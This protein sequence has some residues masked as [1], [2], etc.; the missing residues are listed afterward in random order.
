LNNQDNHNSL[1]IET[2]HH[3][4]FSIVQLPNSDVFIAHELVKTSVGMFTSILLL[5]TLF[6]LGDRFTVT[7]ELFIILPLPVEGGESIGLSHTLT[8]IQ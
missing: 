3:I 6:I 2:P 1:P 7:S 4:I 5:F 8:Y